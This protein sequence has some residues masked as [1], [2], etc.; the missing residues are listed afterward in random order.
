MGLVDTISNA[1]GGSIVGGIKDLI[2]IWKVP[3]EVVLQHQADADKIVADMQTKVLDIVQAESQGQM[4]VDKV[5]AA[6]TSLLVSGWRPM[7]GWVCCSGL[8]I[9]LV[10]RPLFTWAAS[11]CGHPVVFPELDTGTMMEL[12]TGMLGLGG[13]RTYEKLK[14]VAAK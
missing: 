8:A 3:P 5:E 12:L 2:T 10:V 9:Q 11:V 4:D 6:S 14:G 1:M 7:V 13:F